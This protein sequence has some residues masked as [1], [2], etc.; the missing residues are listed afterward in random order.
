MLRYA[1]VRAGSCAE[2]PFPGEDEA[3][4]R[5]VAGPFAVFA[6]RP[7]P[8][9]D[10][11]RFAAE[12]EGRTEDPTDRRKREERE[13]GNV[14]RSQDLPMAA[15]LLGT[16]LILFFFSSIIFREFRHLFSMSLGTSFADL[17]TFGVPDARRL[18]LNLFWQ[19]GKIIAPVIAAAMV[20]GV[21]SNIA[22][23]GFLFTLQPLEMKLERLIP[24][25]KRIVP[26]RR[27]MFSLA[28]IVVQFVAISAATYFVIIDDFIPMLKTEGMDLMQ[29]T[30]LFGKVAFKLMII[31]SIVFLLISIP[32]FMFQRFEYIENLKITVSE[33]KRERRD[34]E[35]D[36]MIRQRQRD[37]A[38]ELR[39]QRNML[40][41]V[42]EADVVITNPTHYAV[43]LRYDPDANP[44]PVVTAKGADHLAFTIRTIAKENGVHIEESPSIA[45]MLYKDV[46]VGQEIPDAMYRVISLIFA[47]LDKFN[48]KA[49]V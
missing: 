40:Q 1:I 49:G 42:P 19:A 33:A 46:E 28:K 10:L 36:P 34:E 45:R 7:L 26:N 32:D 14:A 5:F 27:T 16:V 3:R 2:E 20:M 18:I 31:A 39:N 17:G 38:Y 4:T 15:V 11:Q 30:G 43:A 6:D 13:K 48:R 24:D 22:Q 35:G 12:D 25:F 47:K 37:R 9:Y 29:A 41:A 44:A 8:R 21:V 23:V